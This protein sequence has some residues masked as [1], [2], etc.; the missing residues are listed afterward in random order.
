MLCAS[1]DLGVDHIQAFG[2][3]IRQRPQR[4]QPS[5]HAEPVRPHPK[6]QSSNHSPE[7]S[8][9]M[10]DQNHRHQIVIQ[11]LMYHLTCPAT[12]RAKYSSSFRTRIQKSN[13]LPAIL[14]MKAVILESYFHLF[15]PKGRLSFVPLRNR[16]D[17]P[18]ASSFQ[19][20]DQLQIMSNSI[21]KNKDSI[22]MNYF[23]VNTTQKMAPSIYKD[24]STALCSIQDNHPCHYMCMNHQGILATH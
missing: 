10:M 13:Q 23:H 16:F 20:V 19:I 22:Q 15:Q 4:R 5:H 8:E 7:L 1:G 2:R 17:F 21:Q 9:Q 11:Y 12:E 24:H 6:P 18:H 3:R 14:L